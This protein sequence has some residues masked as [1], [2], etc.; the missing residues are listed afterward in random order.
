P[1]RRARHAPVG[2][3]APADRARAGFPEGRADPDPGRADEL[4]GCPHRAGNHGGVRAA[5]ARAHHLHRGAPRVHARALRRDLR[6]GRR[7]GRACV[8]GGLGASARKRGARL[9]QGSPADM[10]AIVTGMVATYP[11]GGVAWD[12]GQYALGLERLGFE[13]YYLEDTGLESYEPEARTYGPA[14]AYGL[15]FL[16]RS[17]D[18]LSPRLGKRWHARTPD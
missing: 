3:R 4:G 18:E 9:G 14:Y 13:V 1:G 12:Y 17:L 2:R 7:P 6:R 16:Q 10:K 8:G 15:A 5:D 11:V